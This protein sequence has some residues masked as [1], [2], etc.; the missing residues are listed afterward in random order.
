M[1]NAAGAG[2]LTRHAGFAFIEQLVFIA[3]RAPLSSVAGFIVALSASLV[4][5]PQ[6]AILSD[7]MR[8]G[9]SW[10]SQLLGRKRTTML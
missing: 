3:L 5:V 9:V 1:I 8:G 6:P 10:M 4:L 2:I 7:R